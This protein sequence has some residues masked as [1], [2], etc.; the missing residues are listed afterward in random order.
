MWIGWCPFAE[1]VRTFHS[2]TTNGN[3]DPVAVL[4]QGAP[5][6]VAQATRGCLAAGDA[7]TMISAGC[8]VPVDTP[9]ENL[10]AQYRAL[11]ETE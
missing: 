9:H 8:E 5:E 1:A 3:F 10:L 11:C 2:V 6:E 7:R 4:L